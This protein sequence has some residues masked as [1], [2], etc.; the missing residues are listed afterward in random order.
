MLM[1]AQ[2]NNKHLIINSKCS[3]SNN[4]PFLNN[5]EVLSLLF[6]TGIR[7]VVSGSKKKLLIQTPTKLPIPVLAYELDFWDTEEP[8]STCIIVLWRT[9]TTLKYNFSLHVV[10]DFENWAQ[11]DIFF[12]K[13]FSE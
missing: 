2:I 4:F 11:S 3:F 10:K 9:N 7:N 5:T 1:Y 12:S 8:L 13:T 6:S